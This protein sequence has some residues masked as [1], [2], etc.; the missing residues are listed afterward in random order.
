MTTPFQAQASRTN[1]SRSNGPLTEEGKARSSR[2]ALKH[3]MTASTSL[4]SGESVELW[5]QHREG[6]L[7]ALGAKGALETA[8]ADRIALT[9]WRLQRIGACDAT[10]TASAL[11][12]EGASL[13]EAPKLNLVMRYEAHVS[14]QLRQALQALDRLQIIRNRLPALLRFEVED[15]MELHNRMLDARLDAKKRA[16]GTTEENE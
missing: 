9:L 4:I 16:E 1:G 12:A 6:V 2:N 10:T 8:L 7:M 5:R 13:D 11:P 3:G 14:R 15:T